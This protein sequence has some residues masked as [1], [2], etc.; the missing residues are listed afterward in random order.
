MN[1]I[2]KHILGAAF[3]LFW[4]TC[5]PNGGQT[6]LTDDQIAH[7]IADMDVAEAAANGL[8]GYSKD[9]L[10]HFY[11][12]QVLELHGTTK[13]EYEKNLHILADD[14]PRMHAILDQVDQIL[15]P[16]KKEAT[17]SDGKDN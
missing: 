15:E 8:S 6:T 11:Y 13:D 7:I 17:P 1:R 2:L 4:L 3:L 16:G 14:L 10:T 9:S 5:R 12:N